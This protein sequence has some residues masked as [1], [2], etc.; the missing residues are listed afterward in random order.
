M[1]VSTPNTRASAFTTGCAW[2]AEDV[3]GH[4][5]QPLQVGSAI[6]VYV[7]VTENVPA[8]GGVAHWC[9]WAQLQVTDAVVVVKGLELDPMAFSNVTDTE[10]VVI[11]FG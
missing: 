5:A 11:G 4:P 7:G 3:P 1:A 10:P 9:G 6:Q 2:D 8:G